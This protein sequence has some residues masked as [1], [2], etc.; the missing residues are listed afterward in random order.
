MLCCDYIS[1]AADRETWQATH[2]MHM[3][4]VNHLH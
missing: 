3:F 1:Q 4:A 2:N